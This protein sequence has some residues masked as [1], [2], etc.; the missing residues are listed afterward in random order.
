MGQQTR[1]WD[2]PN[3]EE[4]E[5]TKSGETNAFNHPRG[6]YQ[7]P[8]QEQ[9]EEVVPLTAQEIETIRT[10]AYQEGL[11][12]GNEEGFT[13]GKQEGLEK[14]HQE[15]FEV[16]KQEG[17]EAGLLESKTH[18]DEQLNTLGQLIDNLHQPLNKVDADVKNELLI[19][20]TKLAQAM[21]NIEVQQNENVLLQAISDGIKALPINEVSYQITM[22]PSDIEL[23][24]SHFGED[25]ILKNAWQL[26]ES[27]QMARGGC[28]IQTANNA[29]D[30]SIEKRTQAVISQLLLEHGLLDD[31]RTV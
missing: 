6:M 11:L 12:S 21:V 19:L 8:V 30:L 10:Q 23:V 31:P 26:I 27:P 29:V 15:G 13:Q 5:D 14:G 16:G 17:L 28:N 18:I 20:S 4:S 22:H 25:T 2:L 1:V 7:P 9:E 24:Q 3:I